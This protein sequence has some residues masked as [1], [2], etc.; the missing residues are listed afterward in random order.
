MLLQMRLGKSAFE[1]NPILNLWLRL[2]KIIFPERFT[3]PN[4]YSWGISYEYL[5]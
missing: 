4:K 2:I 3:H 5:G 1:K